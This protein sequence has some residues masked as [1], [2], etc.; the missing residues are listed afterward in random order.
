MEQDDEDDGPAPLPPAP[1]LPP[2]ALKALFDQLDG[3]AEFSHFGFHLRH[4]RPI[5]VIN[6]YPAAWQVL[7]S[8]RN[9]IF[10]DP[11]LIWAMHNEGTTRWSDLDA[12]DPYGIIGMSRDHG[13]RYGVVFSLG[14]PESRS[15]G[16][17]SRQDREFTDAEIAE[18]LALVRRIHD[19][20]PN[21]SLSQNQK[22]ALQLV[23]EH[24]TQDE[25]CQILGISRTA[26]K[27]RLT[28]ARLHLGAQS[29]R[30][31]VQVALDTGLIM[32]R[33]GAPISRAL[34]HPGR[35]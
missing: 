30:E 33:T 18:L 7:Y 17:T 4:G 22:I 29:N 16:A 12:H 14:D 20:I 6:T 34:T 11:R 28:R 13:Y 25:I 23:A 31:A 35:Q 26:L 21:P 24:R 1:P 2:A 5:E 15:I 10:C 3:L 8:E 9:F 32:T 19:A 27:K